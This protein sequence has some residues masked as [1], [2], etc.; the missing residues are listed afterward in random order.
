MHGCEKHPDLQDQFDK[1]WNKICDYEDQLGEYNPL[2]P[3][4][5]DWYFANLVGG[6]YYELQFDAPD[7][8]IEQ[9]TKYPERQVCFHRSAFSSRVGVDCYASTDGWLIPAN[10]NLDKFF[11]TTGQKYLLEDFAQ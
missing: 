7:F 8:Y 10:A 9:I 1:V 2:V 6:V 4:I 5:I 3:E 11:F